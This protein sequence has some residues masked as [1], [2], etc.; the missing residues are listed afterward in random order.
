VLE[1]LMSRTGVHEIGERQLVNIPQ[2]L[3]RL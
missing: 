2:P 1:S 3:E